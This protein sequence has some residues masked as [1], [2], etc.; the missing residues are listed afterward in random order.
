MS[1]LVQAAREELFALV[2]APAR[3]LAGLRAEV[4]EL[5]RRLG[6]NSGNSSQ[7]PSADGPAASRSG[8]ARRRS[9]RRPGKQPGAGG[10][11]LFQTSDPDEVVDHLPGAC[12]SCGNDLTGAS[13]A[14]VVRRQVHDIASITPLV[15]EHRLHKRRCGC[16]ATTTAA[17]PAG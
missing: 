14:G 11:V 17:A 3:T 4:A 16:G 7:P 5:K 15:V 12:G 2:A 13:P 8:A 10:S 1:G 6:R 9:G